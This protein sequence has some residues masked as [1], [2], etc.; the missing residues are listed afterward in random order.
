MIRKFITENRK[1]CQ[2][3]VEKYPGY[4]GSEPY[5]RFLLHK[6]QSTL[7]GGEVEK[8]LEVGGIDRPLLR[9]S[10]SF[11]YHGMD[12]E[13]KDKCFEIYDEFIVQSVEDQIEETY[14]LI[15]SITLLEHV[16]NNTK[17]IQSMFFALQDGGVTHH[18]VPS[19]W[20]PY[21]V[22]LRIV[23]P[24]MQKKLIPILRP[25]AK[26]SGYP[27]FFDLCTVSAMENA[28][29]LQGFQNIESTAFYRASDYFAFFIPFFLLVSTFENFCK[30][31]GFTLFAS[32]FVISATK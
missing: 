1:I 27:A 21:S 7:D 30:H 24:V 22:A 31:F 17:S 32:G 12:I 26:N 10:N 3:L 4:F 13:S 15:I 14:D 28:M 9:K 16:Q 25:Q 23:G 29:Q 18:Y 20:H 5:K 6:I 2:Y 19:R 8:V 11:E